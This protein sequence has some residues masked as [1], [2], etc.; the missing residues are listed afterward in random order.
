MGRPARTSAAFE[1]G[2]GSGFKA[3]SH[4]G[5]GGCRDVHGERPAG[6][7]LTC[8]GVSGNELLSFPGAAGVMWL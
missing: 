3:G 1:R 8:V 5:E 7:S 6:P 4:R 2:S